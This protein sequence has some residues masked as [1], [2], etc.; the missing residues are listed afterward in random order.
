MQ[1]YL[2]WQQTDLSFWP[3]GRDGLSRDTRKLLWGMDMF[4]ILIVV[5]VSPVKYVKTLQSIHFKYVQFSVHYLYFNEVKNAS[6]THHY[7]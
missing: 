7:Y 2:Q 6:T 1:T 4:I 3:G 5:M